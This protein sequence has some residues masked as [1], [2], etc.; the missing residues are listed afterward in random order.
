MAL[1][2]TQEPIQALITRIRKIHIEEIRSYLDAH[3]NVHGGGGA[4][5]L[6]HPLASSTNHG[7]MSK[8]HFDVVS[9]LI[10]ET[11][12]ILS[13]TA[14][15]PI[16][17]TGTITAP[18]I[19]I[20]ASSATIPGSMSSAHWTKLN[21][22]PTNAVLN[23]LLAAKGTVYNVTSDTPAVTIT[24]STTTPN[25]AIGNATSQHSGLLTPT[26]K[27]KL[28]AMDGFPI[29]SVIMWY[30]LGLTGNKYEDLFDANGIGKGAFLK[31][32]V[33]NGYTGGPNAPIHIDESG[34]SVGVNMVNRF[35][36][37][38]YYGD[39][40]HR[41]GSVN[42]V[43]GDHHR[44]GEN[45]HVLTAAEL[46]SHSHSYQGD[47]QVRY[48]AGA[49]LGT[50]PYDADSKQGGSGS[51]LATKEFETRGWAHLNMPAFCRFYFL[52]KHTN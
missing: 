26:E 39:P 19:G 42:F 3:I 23:G 1:T 50:F 41:S 36:T 43:E 2:W 7:F 44:S 37:G 27:A 34:S 47:D 46:P 20:D 10:A 29:G 24:T 49:L 16:T 12:G 18:I 15:A 31:W 40:V 22:L 17:K 8:T 13:L 35:P 9:T 21:D 11:N 6:C 5:S 38:A 52:F 30:D 28:E 45:Y 33:L 48:G 32:R 51:I 14:T 25:I 4:S